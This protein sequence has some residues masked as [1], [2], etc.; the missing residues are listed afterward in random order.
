MVYVLLIIFS[1]TIFLFITGIALLKY[2]DAK[3][4]FKLTINYYKELKK[5]TIDSEEISKKII[6]QTE[7][8][9]LLK[10]E[11]ITEDLNKRKEILKEQEIKISGIKNYLE[12]KTEAV[13][14]LHS[15][16]EK[17][18][19]EKIISLEKVSTIKSEE[20]KNQIIEEV[21]HEVRFNA[22][23]NM[24]RII[25]E[26]NSNAQKEAKKII[27]S[28]MQRLSATQS[29]ET[30][31]SLLHLSD[32]QQKGIIIG[33]DGRNIR[34]LEL[35]TGVD[36]I[37]DETP[38]TILI[39]SFDPLRRELAKKSIIKLLEDGRVH[40][41][42]IEE[43]VQNIE[44]KLN[45]EIFNL[46]QDILLDLGINNVSKKITSLI[47]KMKYRNSYS[48]NLLQ[49][50]IEVANL[51]ATIAAELGLNIQKAKRAGLMH[52]MGK[53]STEDPNLTHAILGMKIAEQEGESPE[54]C[55]AIGAHHDEIPMTNTLSPIIQICDSISGSR[56]GARRDTTHQY[57]KRIQELEKIALSYSGVKNCF[58]VQS[59]RELRIIVDSEIVSELECA[60]MVFQVTRQIEKNLQFPGQI[61]V[62][63]IRE[64]R[65]I[66]I[67]KI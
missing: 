67:A 55:N 66:D 38:N 26:A 65:F 41:S 30:S 28:A 5:K 10:Q 22:S 18:K 63:V 14:K 44:K 33:K 4:L 47:G 64:K 3:H 8:E 9:C 36:I 46:G 37:I 34:S 11:K 35:I 16:L 40:P 29:I 43:V 17:I 1:Y 58:A 49:H 13:N 27:I 51:C 54:V 48:Q 39:S 20:A 42:K 21:E 15:D 24:R 19:Q 32:N 52:D 31:T 25:D 62:T 53:V 56:P 61:K 12:R 45:D 50:S 57:L 2:I 59:G 60:N 23:L 7:L 6:E